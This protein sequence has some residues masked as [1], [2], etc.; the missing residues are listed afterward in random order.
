MSNSLPS[1]L[2]PTRQQLDELDALIQQMLNLPVKH[3]DA[4]AGVVAPPELTAVPSIAANDSPS[5]SIESRPMFRNGEHTAIGGLR[6]TMRSPDDSGS[7]P[8]EMVE[9]PAEPG[10][11]DPA[12]G[13]PLAPG[14]PSA[15]RAEPEQEPTWIS[16]KVGERRQIE[17]PSPGRLDR[18]ASGTTLWLVP[19]KIVNYVFD[20]GT[21]PFDPL[22][23][24][25]RRDTGRTFVGWT[26]LILLASAV[27]WA[28]LERIGWTW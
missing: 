24:W 26:G 15:F 9:R 21:Y 27:A 25:L 12:I 20:G 5:A 28:I 6:E 3:F 19:L 4:D 8:G 10:N 18:A 22:G 13:K 7:A 11:R 2:D 16:K 23:R 17:R 1:A 14:Q